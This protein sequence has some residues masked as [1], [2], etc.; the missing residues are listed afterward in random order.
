MQDSPV[1]IEKNNKN[2]IQKTNHEKTK[3]SLGD[4]WKRR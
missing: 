2:L 1:K 3:D 4:N